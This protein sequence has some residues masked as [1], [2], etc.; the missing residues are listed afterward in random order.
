[1]AAPPRLAGAAARWPR[2]CVISGWGWESCGA[3][4]ERIHGVPRPYRINAI[5]SWASHVKMSP[6]FV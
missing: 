1:V 5:L 6:P 2:R 4:R 3:P